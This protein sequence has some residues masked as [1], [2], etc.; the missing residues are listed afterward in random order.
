MESMVFVLNFWLVLRALAAL[1][2][3]TSE[4]RCQLRRVIKPG[5][6][7]HVRVSRISPGVIG[8]GVAWTDVR[9]QGGSS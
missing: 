6:N 5:T 4:C 8:C 7:S 1:E 3:V 2:Q 9:P